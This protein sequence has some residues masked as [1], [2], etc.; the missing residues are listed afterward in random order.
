M[1][2]HKPVSRKIKQVYEE[3]SLI[4]LFHRVTFMPS[5]TCRD[6]AYFFVA[7]MSEANVGGHEVVLDLAPLTRATIAFEDLVP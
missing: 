1:L 2:L 3:P 4:E 6:G 7:H 5:Y